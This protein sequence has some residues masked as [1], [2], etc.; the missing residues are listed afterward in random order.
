MTT[1]IFAPY[2]VLA[3]KL[4]PHA[5]DS[6]EDGSHDLS[7]L[8]RVWKNAAIIQQTEGGDAEVLCAAALLHD[9]VSVEKN[10]PDRHRA[11]RFAAEKA[12]SLLRE[13]SWSEERIAAT[14]HAIEAHS[15]SANIEP[16]TVEAKILQDADR[17]DAIGV[18][19]AARCFYI[20]GRMGSAL[21]DWQD[22]QA[23][24]RPLDDKRYALDHFRAKL[25]KLASGFKTETGSRMATER[26]EKLEAIFNDFLCEAGS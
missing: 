19:G 9:C 25:F 6:H 7:H 11:S 20:A 17:L 4:L 26:H 3:A 2:D 12:T 22:P 13:L 15:F 14:A 23:E 1:Q 10:A 21:Y 24:S 16:R 18:I 8:A 5:L